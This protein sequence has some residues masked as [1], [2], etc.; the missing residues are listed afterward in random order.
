MTTLIQILKFLEEYKILKKKIEAVSFNK[1]Y[2]LKNKRLRLF[3]ER[4]K[5]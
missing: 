4:L 2:Y 1:L 3:I 5:P